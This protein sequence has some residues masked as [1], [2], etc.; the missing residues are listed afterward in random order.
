[1]RARRVIEQREAHWL[2]I[3][4]LLVG[5]WSFLSGMMVSRFTPKACLKKKRP[6]P[7]K[8]PVSSRLGLLAGEGLGT[9]PRPCSLCNF[10][11]PRLVL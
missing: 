2:M 8:E 5:L 3:S 9:R 7:L 10:I 1:M 11:L 4:A 6:V